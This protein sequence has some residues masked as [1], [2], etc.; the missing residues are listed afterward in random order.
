MQYIPH[1]VQGT[2]HTIYTSNI[3]DCATQKFEYG[4]G[5]HVCVKN[6]RSFCHNQTCNGSN[7]LGRT[8]GH[9]KF[10]IYEVNLTIIK[11]CDVACSNTG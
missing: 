7:L 8:T 4:I 3:P 1:H 5:S 11:I 9:R 2:S 6:K 10:V